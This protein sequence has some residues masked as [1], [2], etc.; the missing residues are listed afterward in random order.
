MQPLMGRLSDRSGI[1]RVIVIGI[2]TAAVCAFMIPIL[3]NFGQLSMI[4][5]LLLVGV[6]LLEGIRSSVLAA[7]VDFTGSREGTT[8]GFAFTMMDGI[9]AFG[10]LLAG[11]AAGIQFSHAFLLAGI[12][13][14]FSMILCFYV[15]F[16]PPVSS[17]QSDK[18]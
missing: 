6:G 8:I 13:C 14:T 17:T 4:I 15:S 1:H 12:L 2:A 9:G 7:A 16:V 18:T 10:A 11:W 5:M 3:E